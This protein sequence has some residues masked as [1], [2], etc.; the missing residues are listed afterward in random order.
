[1]WRLSATW[2]ANE[3]SPCPTGLVAIR[4]VRD[5]GGVTAPD[6]SFFPSHPTEQKQPN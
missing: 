6:F 5:D 3:M 1:M 4:R 2:I